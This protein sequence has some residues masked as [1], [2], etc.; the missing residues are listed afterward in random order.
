MIYDVWDLSKAPMKEYIEH[1]FEKLYSINSYTPSKQ[2]KETNK[3]SAVF[4]IKIKG[5]EKYPSKKPEKLDFLKQEAKRLNVYL[6]FSF[7]PNA[8]IE[9]RK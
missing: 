3:L 9:Q 5:Q 1:A 8:P 6:T 2:S 7:N 4:R